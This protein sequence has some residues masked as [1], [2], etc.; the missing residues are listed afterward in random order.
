MQATTGKR[1]NQ[2]PRSPAYASEPD[3]AQNRDAGED[4]DGQIWRS[5]CQQMLQLRAPA[6]AHQPPRSP[7]LSPPFNAPA[8]PPHCL[9][10]CGQDGFPQQRAHWQEPMPKRE[11][12][13]LIDAVRDVSTPHACV[14]L[15]HFAELPIYFL[16]VCATDMAG[17]GWCC[18]VAAPWFLSYFA[19]EGRSR[20]AGL[21]R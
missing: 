17:Y 6:S 9:P 16:S 4:G 11:Q 3:Q 8:D 2:S 18:T 21:A 20:R 19:A 15:E 5:M 12:R 13:K 10:S 14:M 1:R 7:P